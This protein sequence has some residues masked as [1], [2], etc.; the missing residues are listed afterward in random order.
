MMLNKDIE[1]AGGKKIKS[2]DVTYVSLYKEFVCQVS[3][4]YEMR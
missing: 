3:K 1:K 4:E 2:V